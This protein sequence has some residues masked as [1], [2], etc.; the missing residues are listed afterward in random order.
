M[1]EIFTESRLWFARETGK[2]NWT[3]SS[4]QLSPT[5]YS[6]YFDI[7]FVN[8]IFKKFDKAYESIKIY[9]KDKATYE[10]LKSHIDMEWLFPAKVA[11]SSYRDSYRSDDMARIMKNFKDI[12][13]S[14]R[15]S[16]TGEESSLSVDAFLSTF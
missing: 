1:K 11:I 12:C 4:I 6:Q 7:G 10:T 15:I 8:G 14:L 16:R 5:V 9:E 13:G 2:N 3:S